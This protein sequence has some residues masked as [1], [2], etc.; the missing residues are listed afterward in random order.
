M[1]KELSS[2][3]TGIHRRVDELGRVVIPAEIRKLLGIDLKDMMVISLEGS[4]IVLQKANVS[5]IFCG[6]EAN[7]Q[8]FREKGICRRCRMRLL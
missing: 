5:C 6:S 4:S 3:T 1:S 2:R 8:T 7:V